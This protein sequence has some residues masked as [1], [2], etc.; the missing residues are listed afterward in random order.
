MYSISL[1]VCVFFFPTLFLARFSSPLRPHLPPSAAWDNQVP[2]NPRRPSHQHRER[3]VEEDSE[4]AHWS[5]DVFTNYTMA[6]RA[7]CESLLS[8]SVSMADIITTTQIP[9]AQ[10]FSF[11][12]VCIRL[13]RFLCAHRSP[14]QGGWN[15]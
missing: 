6:H 3:E 12:E 1:C 5:V 8:M 14:L 7:P 4:S 9:P 2:T 15:R 13:H 11:H 10:R